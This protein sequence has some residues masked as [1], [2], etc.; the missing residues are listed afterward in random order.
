MRNHQASQKKSSVKKALA[1]T[2]NPLE[3][4]PFAV[5]A[6]HE[7]TERSPSTKGYESAMPELA[8]LNPEGGR[9]M[10]VQPKLEIGAPGDKYE[11]EAD[12]VASQVV[13]RLNAPETVRPGEDETVQR[14]EM[15]TKDNKARL[16]RSPILQR[17][18][19]DGGMAATPD[20]EASINR[21]RGG[22]QP[23]ADNIRQPMEK[24]LGA[25][26]SRVKVHTDR[27]ADQLNQ[28]IQAKAFTTRQDVFFRQG[29]YNP[30]SRNGQEL[31]AHELTH[32]IQQNGD[33]IQHK[34]QQRTIGKQIE[35]SLGY[36]DD[37]RKKDNN[38]IQRQVLIKG[39]GILQCAVVRSVSDAGVQSTDDQQAQPLGNSALS[40]GFSRV[41]ISITNQHG[42][43]TGQLVQRT[44]SESENLSTEYRIRAIQKS[45]GGDTSKQ[46]KEKLKERFPD[47][48]PLF[49]ESQLEQIQLM[50]NDNDKETSKWLQKAGIGR[51]QEAK[52][53]LETPNFKD[54]LKLEPGK[55]LLIATLAWKKGRGDLNDSPSPAYSLAR[56]MM[57]KNGNLKEE[58]QKKLIQERDSDIHNAFLK[59]LKI[60]DNTQDTEVPE[61]EKSMAMAASEILKKIFLILQSGLQIY[62]KEQSQHIDYKDGDVARALAHGGRVNIRIPALQKDDNPRSL[63]EWI[64]I[65]KDGKLANSVYTRRFATHGV[66]I[67]KNK[68]KERGKFEETGGRRVSAMNFFKPNVEI[69]GQD[70]AAGG[71]GKRDINGDVI[72]VDGAHGHMFIEFIHPTQEKDGALQ[73]GMETTAPGAGSVVGYKHNLLSTEKTANP[74][75][76]F[77]GYKTDK[78][79][80]GG[81]KKTERYVDLKRYE[82]RDDKKWL[83]YLKDVEEDW[84]QILKNNNE[85]QAFGQLIG[86]RQYFGYDDEG[87]LKRQN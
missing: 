3:S 48:G 66:N 33:V 41:P 13:Q 8:I 52:D 30:G 83:D 58:E 1:P 29:E 25:D 60:E 4:R 85:D 20:L 55:R 79:G 72:L 54:W 35:P 47:K 23:M 63:M 61:D 77:H 34:K 37:V 68:G 43:P 86:K 5:Q 50:S 78:I 70:Q 9:A 44:N 42:A 74:E 24:A 56:Q 39:S 62:N 16:M 7:E 46:C 69:L 22:G 26:F 45:I 27:Q 18:S 14:E 12:R 53:Y 65:T 21:A 2:P 19:S 81:L 40:K 36:T 73:I 49:N 80:E 17:R 32:V 84:N 57:I 6:T 87:N 11:Q 10:P 67:T 82:T 71:V 15:E 75:S 28:S 51:Y 76:S 59:T 64:G 38:L 31:I